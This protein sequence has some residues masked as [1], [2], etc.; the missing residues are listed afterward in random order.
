MPETSSFLLTPIAPHN[1]N[2]RPLLICDDCKLTLKI[3]GRENEH[4]ISLDSRTHTLPNETEIT[5]KKANFKVNMVVLNNESFLK[6]LRE[7]MLWGEDKR[8]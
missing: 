4:L 7:K 8:N 3:S 1:L 5:I 6:T 2:M